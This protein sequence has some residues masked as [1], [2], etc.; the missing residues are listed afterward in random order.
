MKPLFNIS[1]FHFIFSRIVA[2]FAFITVYFWIY[3]GRA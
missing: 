1:E 2:G 3:H